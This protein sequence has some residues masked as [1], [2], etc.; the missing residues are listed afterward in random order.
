MEAAKRQV[1]QGLVRLM[2]EL[3]VFV[4]IRL[5]TDDDN[6]ISYY[7]DLDEELEWPLE[8]LDDIQSE[9]KEIRQRGNGWLTYSPLS[10]KIREG[11]TFVKLLDLLDERCL[12]PTEVSV[13]VQ[14]LLRQ[15]HEEPMPRSAEDFC[16]ALADALERTPHVYDPLKGS[17]G[18]AIKLSNVKWAVHGGL[19]GNLRLLVQTLSNPLQAVLNETCAAPQALTQSELVF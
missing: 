19:A 4:V 11:G 5:T 8:V 2:S 14:L 1:V 3:S 6:V 16:N 15:E 9:A 12:T 13:F 17:M 18:P 10:H 7:N